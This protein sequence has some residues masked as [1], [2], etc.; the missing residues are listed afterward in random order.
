MFQTLAG[1]IFA[2]FR[3]CRIFDTVFHLPNKN[4]GSVQQLTRLC[5]AESAINGN[6][7]P[8]NFASDRRSVP[9]WVPATQSLLSSLIPLLL[10]SHPS[11]LAQPLLPA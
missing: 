3:R 7:A 2:S 8:S 9:I 1:G 6:P 10:P 5:M 4:Y 11:P